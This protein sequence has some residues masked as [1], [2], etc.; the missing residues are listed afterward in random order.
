[1]YNTLLLS[2][3]QVRFDFFSIFK[4]KIHLMC[5]TEE[6]IKRNT[7]T[8]HMKKK[9]HRSDLNKEKNLQEKLC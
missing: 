2:C 3:L 4:V 1:M 6:G 9:Y 8:Y 5:N 7:I